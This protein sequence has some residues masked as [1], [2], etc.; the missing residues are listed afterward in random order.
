MAF[1]D[2]INPIFAA[3]FCRDKSKKEEFTKAAVEKMKFFFSKIEKRYI[4]LDKIKIF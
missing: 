4:K 2:M 3:L 1:D